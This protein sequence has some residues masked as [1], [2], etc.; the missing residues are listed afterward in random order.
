MPLPDTLVSFSPH[1]NPG[2]LLTP[3]YT[4]RGGLRQGVLSKVTKLQGMK[5]E[6]ELRSLCLQSP[7]P[8][9]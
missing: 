6:F 7:C 2:R 8:Q 1:S 4:R 9:P 3:F 5:L